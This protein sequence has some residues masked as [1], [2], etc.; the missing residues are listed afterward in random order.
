MSAG[1]SFEPVPEPPEQNR[2]FII[3]AIG[4]VGMLVLGLLGIGGYVVFS[5]SKRPTQAQGAAQL[6]PVVLL[7]TSTATIMA[8][9]TP[10]VKTTSTPVVLP[11]T[12]T[13]L[14]VV[15]QPTTT[16]MTTV[17]VVKPTGAGGG[18][19]KAETP[20][21]GAAGTQGGG[22]GAAGTQGGGPGAAGT[23]G[24]GPGAAGTQGGGAV[25]PQTPAAGAAPVPQVPTTQGTEAPPNT[26]FGG[27]GVIGLGA[28]LAGIAFLARRL[29]LH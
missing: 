24:G 4:L 8:T 17:V 20:A 13:A 25:G 1:I 3:I 10:T 29:R 2:L 23:Q 7:A 28:G 12:P 21:A 9:D 18:F 11:P 22:P 14:V 27:L 5:R 26:G 15:I 19:F 6:T 16:A